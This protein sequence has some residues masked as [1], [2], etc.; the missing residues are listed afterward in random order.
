[1]IQTIR[2]VDVNADGC[3]TDIDTYV[4]VNGVLPITYGIIERTRSAIENFKKEN[5]DWQTDDIIDVA[6]QHLRKEGYKTKII[7]GFDYEIDY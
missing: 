2:F 7:G 3:G 4:Q 1:M 5:E 6:R